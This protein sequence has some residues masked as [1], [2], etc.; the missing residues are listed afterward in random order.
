MELTLR[1]REIVAAVLAGATD[2]AKLSR[3]FDISERTARTHLSNIYAKLGVSNLAEMIV[4][5]MSAAAEREA[6]LIERVRLLRLLPGDVIC[7]LLDSDPGDER[8][9]EI[10]RQV[11]AVAPAWVKVL[12]LERA[13]LRVLRSNDGGEHD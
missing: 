3:Q 10:W 11:R 4:T 7:V 8:R 6:T 9:V 12:V 5:Q 1:E 13:E 2:A